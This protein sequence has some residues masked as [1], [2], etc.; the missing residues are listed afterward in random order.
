MHVA[1]AEDDPAVS[2]CALQLEI[3][4]PPSWKATVP[5][6]TVAPVVPG[7]TVAVYVTLPPAVGLVLDADRP[8]VVVPGLTVSV[9]AALVDPACPDPLAGVNAAVSDSGDPAAANAVEHVA[10]PDEPLATT[11]WLVQPEIADP[12]AENPTVPEGVAALVDTV[13]VNMTA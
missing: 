13:A 3:E 5:E 4:L 6:G 8:V 12:L 11:G 7:V 1:V 10:V 2:A 9:W